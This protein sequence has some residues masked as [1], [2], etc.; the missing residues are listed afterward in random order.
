MVLRWVPLVEGKLR[1]V[2]VVVERV[3]RMPQLFEVDLMR[4]RGKKEDRGVE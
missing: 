3:A 4:K 1:S 2:S